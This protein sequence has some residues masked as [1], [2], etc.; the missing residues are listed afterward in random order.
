MKERILV[1]GAGYAGLLAAL[2]TAK[3]TRG[4]A[5]V[6]LV[7]ADD[8]FCERIRLHQ[9][10]AGARLERRPIQSLLAGTDVR[11]RKGLVRELR[12]AAGEVLMDG[13]RL[14][15]D[16]LIYALGSQV[17]VARV[18]GVR[19][20]AYTLD[21][22]S[23]RRLSMALPDVAGRGGHLLVVGG[24]LTGI[25]AASEL[26]EAYPTLRVTLLCQ[27]ELAPLLSGRGQ[28]YIRRAL[29]Q[30]GVALQEHMVVQALEPGVA[31]SGPGG[32]TTLAF[33]LCVWAGGFVALPLGREAGLAVNERNQIL[34]DPWLRALSQPAIYVAGDA[35]APAESVGA[36]ILMTCKTAM[37][38]GAHAAD[39]VS[40]AVLGKPEARFGFGDTGVCVSLGRR[41][42]LIQVMRQDGRPTDRVFTGRVGAWIKERICRLTVTMLRAERHDWWRYRWRSAPAGAAERPALEAAKTPRIA[43]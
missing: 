19:E 7:S 36:P 34:V 14:G 1:L 27:G 9:L 15:Y 18:P 6:M 40:R 24:G 10:A 16:R 4:R 23:A 33:D 29:T 30:K 37:P 25:E 28:S 43:A 35:A 21:A 5:E 39:N 11:F 26:A 32:K 38:L 31:H 42:A 8:T 2:R 3:Q 17:D 41:D 12:P 13:E 22:G 20:H